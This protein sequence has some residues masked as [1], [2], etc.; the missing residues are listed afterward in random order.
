MPRKVSV[1]LLL[2]AAGAGAAT[3]APA[4]PPT[5]V[6]PARLVLAGL[7]AAHGIRQV[8]RFHAGGPFAADPAFQLLTQPGRALDPGRLLVALGDNLGAP[9]AGGA[10]DGGTILSIDPSAGGPGH[11]LALPPLAGLLSAAPGA[12]VQLW[13]NRSASFLNRVHNPGS[14]TADE[15]AAAGPRYLS[16]NNAFGRPWLANAPFGRNGPGTETVVDPDGA[17]LANA[18]SDDAGGV[19][20]GRT[21]NRTSVPKAV[22][23]GPWA[24]LWNRRDSGQLMAGGIDRGAFGTALLGASPDGSGFAV[25][26][27]VTGTGAVAQVHVQDGVDGLAPAGTVALGAGDP[28][29]IGVAFKWS[30]RPALF[31]AEAARDRIAVLRLGNDAR[32]FTLEGVDR[33]SSPWLHQPVDL[34]AATPEIANPRFASHTTLAGGSDLIV[35]NRGDGSLL[36]LRQDGTVVARAFLSLPNGAGIGADRLGALAV[37]GDGRRLW[38]VVQ[39]P[40]TRLS[41]LLEVSGFDAAGALS[42]APGPEV[43]PSGRPPAGEAEAGSRL[44]AARVDAAGGLGPLFNAD[45]CAACHPGGT[46]ASTDEAHFARRVA[47]LDERTGRILPIAGNPSAIA[48]RRSVRDPGLLDGPSAGLPREADVVSL[49]MPLALAVAGRIDEIDDATIEAQAVAKGDGIHGRAHRVTAADGRPRVGRYG[50]KADVAT[51]DE[52]VGAALGNEMGVTSALAPNPVVAPE[53]DGR[54]ARA[55]SAYLRSLAAPAHEVTR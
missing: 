54:R 21:T 8:G 2:L 38:V 26:A 19:F 46:G 47:H 23:S 18:P 32:H 13:S 10:Q 3:P 52:M 22:R 50:W 40:G 51:L 34:A 53:D 30:G 35:T 4:T 48:P 12:A 11:P 17:P 33:L 55:I 9:P 25:F 37:S 1:A 27:V 14:R 28:G 7:P 5:W 16:I 44:F 29:V 24:S 36:R 49:R 39:R 6:L 20:L 31:V 42:S 41:D 15:A 45:S 43:E